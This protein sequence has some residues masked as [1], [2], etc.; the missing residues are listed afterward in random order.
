[1]NSD[2]TI[3]MYGQTEASPRMS[4]LPS[5]MMKNKLGSIGVP[6]PGGKFYLIDESNQIINDPDVEGEL[7]Y[8]GDNVCLGY[9]RNC[10]D[11]ASGDSNKGMLKTGDIAKV[12]SDGFC[13]ITG[14]KKRFL[15]L[16][17]QSR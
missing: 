16:F 5:I 7:V 10:N 9:A 13:Y 12:D 8:E 17:W 2:Q 1:M 6:I 14:R 4:Y 15:K 3:V 11:L